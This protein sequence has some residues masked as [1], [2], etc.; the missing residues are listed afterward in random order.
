MASLVRNFIA[1]MSTRE[2]RMAVAM[3]VVMLG[4]G[5]GLAIYLVRSSIS[6]VKDSFDERANILKTIEAERDE[7]LAAKRERKLNKKAQGKPMPLRTLVDKVAEQ[8]EVTVPDVK[9]IPDKAGDVWIEHAVELSIRDVGLE[10]MT[11][12]MEEVEDYHN[13]VRQYCAVGLVEAFSGDSGTSC[14]S[15]RSEIYDHQLSHV[16]TNWDGDC[17]RAYWTR[18]GI[19]RTE[20][21]RY[22]VMWLDDLALS[23]S[24][25]FSSGPQLRKPQDWSVVF[26]GDFVYLP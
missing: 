9:E 14:W 18:S 20:D 7:Y 11:R 12:F 23:G 24:S 26:G 21:G 3:L 25:P 17:S 5:I 10:S 13:G 19:R 8:T 1:G 4:M 15:E 16:A 6:E 22:L 2:K